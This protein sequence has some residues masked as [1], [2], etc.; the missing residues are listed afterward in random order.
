MTELVQG[1]HVWADD[2][3]K[4]HRNDDRDDEHEGGPRSPHRVPYPDAAQ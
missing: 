3:G 4:D 1:V 2:S